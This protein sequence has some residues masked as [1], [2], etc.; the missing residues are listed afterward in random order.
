M[1]R[2]PN[3]PAKPVAT[4]EILPE[5]LDAVAQDVVRKMYRHVTPTQRLAERLGQGELLLLGK[6]PDA[7]SVATVGRLILEY[8]SKRS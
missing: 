5:L 4:Q 1:R 8:A 3:H 2:T 7:A 6:L